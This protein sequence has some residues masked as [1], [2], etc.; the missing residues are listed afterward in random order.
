MFCIAIHSRFCLHICHMTWATFHFLAYLARKNVYFPLSDSLFFR[1]PQTE[2]RTDRFSLDRNHCCCS[3]SKRFL[4]LSYYIKLNWR[5]VIKWKRKRKRKRAYYV[6]LKKLTFMQTMLGH[7]VWI[8][9]WFL[10]ICCRWVRNTQC[11][12]NKMWHSVLIPPNIEKLQVSNFG[13]K[14]KKNATNL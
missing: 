10:V 6:V 7:C 2:Q 11:W 9:K 3:Y 1:C 5:I 4:W 12:V 14:L 8:N 13:T